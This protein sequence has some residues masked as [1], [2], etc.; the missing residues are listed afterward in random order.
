M[1]HQFFA[2]SQNV[3]IVFSYN[4]PSPDPKQLARCFEV[5][6]IGE[7]LLDRGMMVST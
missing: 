2:E 7:Y 6:G 3:R 1:L 4:P 5:F